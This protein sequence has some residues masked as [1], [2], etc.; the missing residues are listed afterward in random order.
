MLP[1]DI[2]RLLFV[3]ASVLSRVEGGAFGVLGWKAYSQE[4]KG[5]SGLGLFGA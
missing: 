3:E 4:L 2:A 1:A 5:F